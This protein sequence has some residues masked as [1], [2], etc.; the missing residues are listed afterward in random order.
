[1]L[2]AARDICRLSRRTQRIV[3]AFSSWCI[4]Q[5]CHQTSGPQKRGR[6][7]LCALTADL[8]AD[9]ARRF[10]DRQSV[11]V[12]GKFPG[13]PTALVRERQLTESGIAIQLFAPITPPLSSKWS[14]RAGMTRS[15]WFRR[16][17]IIPAR[18]VAQIHNPQQRHAFRD[19]G[20][21]LM[22]TCNDAKPVDLRRRAV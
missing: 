6:F 11:R 17:A 22:L 16:E 4:V 13:Y 12:G 3:R 14:V 5:W 15:R 18:I 8:I 9:E 20:H 21:R 2:C 10:A 1:M 7:F 19:V